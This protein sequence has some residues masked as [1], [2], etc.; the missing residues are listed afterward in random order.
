MDL[1]NDGG[2]ESPSRLDIV[3]YLIKAEIKNRR[4]IK[5]LENLGFDPTLWSLDFSDMILDLAGFAMRTDDV[6]DRYSQLLDRYVERLHPADEKDNVN[7]LA[8]DFYS[9]LLS[10]KSR[11]DGRA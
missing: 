9:K 8:A 2:G 4:F 10:E 7:E 1:S 6:Y 11:L 3:L 5:G